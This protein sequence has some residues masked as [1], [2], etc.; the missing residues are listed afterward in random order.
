MSE[1]RE[2]FG[3]GVLCSECCRPFYADTLGEHSVCVDKRWHRDS[4]GPWVLDKRTHD[5]YVTMLEIDPRYN[6]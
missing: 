3:V 2:V 5:L 6:R 4:E 1:R